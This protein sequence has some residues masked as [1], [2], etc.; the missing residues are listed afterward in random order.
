MAL[1]PDKILADAEIASFIE[2]VN[3]TADEIVGDS[4]FQIP[5]P[6]L[7]GLGLLIKL[8]IRAFEKS[9]AASFAPIFI[10]K[11]IIQD[12]KESPRRFFSIINDGLDSIKTLF[13]NPIQFIIDEGIN[14]PLEIFPFPVRILFGGVSKDANRLKSLIDSAQPTQGSSVLQ[15]YNY[16]LVLNAVSPPAP[17]EAVSTASDVNSIKSI[18]VNYQTKT[19]GEK[20]PVQFL[21]EGDTFSVSDGNISSTYRVSSVQPGNEFAEIF[22]QLIASNTQN[23]GDNKTISIPG[24]KD[25]GIAVSRNI[26]LREFLTPDG[27]LII[28]FSVLGINLPLLSKLGFEIGNFS[29]LK[30]DNPTKEFVVGLEARSGLKFNQVFT[31][32]ID[33]VFPEIDWQ[34]LS[35]EKSNGN[36]NSKEVSKEEI[37]SLARLLQIGSQNPF[38]LI[39]IILNYVKLLLLPIQLV[40]GV[41]KSLASSITNPISLIKTVILF[42]TDPL[43][44]L[45]NIISE[46]FLT[47]L[48]PYLEPIISPIIPYSEAVQDPNDKNRGLKPL[49]SDLICGTFSAKLNNYKPNPNFFALQRNNLGQTVTD[50]NTSIQLPFNLEE[51]KQIPDQGEIVTNSNNPSQ[52]TSLRISTVTNTI[53]DSLAYLA[54]VQVGSVISLSV[55][56]KYQ[57]YLV[58]SKT[59]QQS[60]TGNYFEYL[61]QPTTQSIR[62]GDPAQNNTSVSPRFSATLS[63]DNPNKTFLFIIEKYLPLKL[64]ER[65]E[66]IKG[67]LAITIALAVEIPLLIPA[68]F[69]SLFG[70]EK[71]TSPTLAASSSVSDVLSLLISFYIQ[72]G[73]GLNNKQSEIVSGIIGNNNSNN[74][75]GIETIF[76]DLSDSLSSQSKNT[77]IYKSNISP[78]V[79]NQFRYYQISLAKLGE[80]VKVLLQIYYSIRDIRTPYIFKKQ[81]V[82]KIYALRN[83][84][85]NILFNKY[86]EVGIYAAFQSF[87]V[88][89]NETINLYDDIN[90]DQT[91]PY[92]KNFTG[93]YITGENG[94]FVYVQPLRDNIIRNLNFIS[95]YILPNYFQS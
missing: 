75:N 21:K 36:V 42:L 33:G 74:S 51:N 92:V 13:T 30:D 8:Q 35:S 84:N 90:L 65:W 62:S 67:I 81:P 89:N 6:S 22:L 28:P 82:G 26:T 68:V 44:A 50:Q 1:L 45:C 52:V 38:F 7:P 63:I 59:F 55:S 83:G 15:E 78:D 54:S 46:S 69:K 14:G 76:Y 73:G 3:V 57:T 47:F 87:K 4:K 24:F 85:V 80:N 10:G 95:T 93:I 31:S 66:S 53:E 41:F 94:Q 40:L 17:G 49:F 9:I 91:L 5:N 70:I 88:I 25:S 43:K 61:V 77:V 79:R 2:R 27:R 71:G 60:Q 48:R 34:N 19:T 29:N 18:S 39:K 86:E 23:S 32:M 16:N 58:S 72:P 37:T 56:N 64:I 11:K 12:A 20:A